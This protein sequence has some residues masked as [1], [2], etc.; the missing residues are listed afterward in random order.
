MLDQGRPDSPFIQ[1]GYE[2]GPSIKALVAPGHN[3]TPTEQALYDA[4]YAARNSTDIINVVEPAYNGRTITDTNAKIPLFVQKSTYY[5]VVDR[6]ILHLMRIKQIK[7]FK[8][9]YQMVMK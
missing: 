1:L 4:V 9:M 6:I 2:V 7:L 8:I 3:L 5:R